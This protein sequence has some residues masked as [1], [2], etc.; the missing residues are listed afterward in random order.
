VRSRGYL[1]ERADG[2]GQ[3]APDVGRPLSA[4]DGNGGGRGGS[5]NGDADPA[6]VG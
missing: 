3:V 2:G 5:R 6:S 1:L 4:R